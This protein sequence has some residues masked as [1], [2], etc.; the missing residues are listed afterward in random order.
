MAAEDLHDGR[1]IEVGGR[2]SDSLESAV[3]LA[4]ESGDGDVTIDGQDGD[5]LRREGRS[6]TCRES[7]ESNATDL[8]VEVV[9]AHLGHSSNAERKRHRGLGHDLLP[10]PAGDDARDLDGDER[11]TNADGVEEGHGHPS[12]LRVAY[13]VQRRGA[14]RSGD[15]VELADRLAL[16]VLAVNVD[17]SSGL[18]VDGAKS[19]VND[20]CGSRSAKVELTRWSASARCRTSRPARLRGR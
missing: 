14:S 2:R 13:G 6:A 5:G 15:A 1:L 12:E 19:S 8:E 10:Q 3:E 16:T 17:A 9:L 11:V 7:W 20:L 4:G 18:V